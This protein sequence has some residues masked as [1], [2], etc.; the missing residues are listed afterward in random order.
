MEPRL[1]TG[2]AA[3]ISRRLQDRMQLAAD[4]PERQWPAELF[5]ERLYLQ[6]SARLQGE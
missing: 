3:D 4:A 2:L 1:R 5:L 6:L